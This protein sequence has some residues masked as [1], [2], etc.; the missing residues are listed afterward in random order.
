MPWAKGLV[1]GC[2]GQVAWTRAWVVS[3]VRL[4]VVGSRAGGGR[5]CRATLGGKGKGTSERGLDLDERKSCRSSRPWFRDSN[6]TITS[7][8]SSLV[9]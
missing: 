7:I 1:V 6:S 5:V 9:P 8:P 3:T 4:V 2:G